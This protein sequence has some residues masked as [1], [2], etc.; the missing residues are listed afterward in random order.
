MHT[1]K[2]LISKLIKLRGEEYEEGNFRS[3][4][5]LWK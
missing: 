4:S 2:I 1:L 5:R 3:M